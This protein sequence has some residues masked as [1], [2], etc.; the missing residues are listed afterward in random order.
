MVKWENS[1]RNTL[2]QIHDNSIFKIFVNM[3]GYIPSS[4]DTHKRFREI[5]PVLLAQYGWKAGYMRLFKE[6][7]EYIKDTTTRGIHCIAAAYA[8]QDNIKMELFAAMYNHE[9]EHYFADPEMA[10]KW[11]EDLRMEEI[12]GRNL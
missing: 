8:H 12:Y 1:I 6:E 5:L 4:I 7:A 9:S 10:R 11:I 3:Y 2:D